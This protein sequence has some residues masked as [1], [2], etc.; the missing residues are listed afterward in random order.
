M[1]E[2][3][4]ALKKEDFGSFISERGLIVCAGISCFFEIEVMSEEIPNKPVNNGRRESF[5]GRFMV[6][7][8][9]KPDNRNMIKAHMREVFSDPIRKIDAVISINGIILSA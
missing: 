6:A 4:M 3:K 2:A 9:R 8:P 1:N 5:I 7:I